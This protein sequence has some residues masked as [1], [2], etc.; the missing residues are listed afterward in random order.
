ME[1]TRG[2][3]MAVLAASVLGLVLTAWNLA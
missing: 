1:M 3:R 2:A